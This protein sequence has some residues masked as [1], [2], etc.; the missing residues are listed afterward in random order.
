MA[1]IL[2]PVF[3]QAKLAAKKTQGLV[4]AK[5]SSTSII[6][7]SADNNDRLP[8]ADRWMDAVNL[9]RQKVSTYYCISM[10]RRKK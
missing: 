1:A 7:Y 5:L 10:Y 3:S 4:G 6:L 8:I 9:W 2:F